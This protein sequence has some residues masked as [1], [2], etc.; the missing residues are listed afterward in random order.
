MTDDSPL[1]S[2][3]GLTK[4]YGELTAVENLSLDIAP[5][6]IF[7]MLGPNGAGKTT[8]ISC[9]SGLLQHFEG[10]VRVA[11]YDVLEHFR[12]TRQIVGVVPQE[13]NFDAFC[14]ARQTLIYQGG[15]FGRRRARQRADELLTAFGLSEKAEAN[16]RW[17]SGGM[18]RRLM[19]CKALM[20]QPA[21]LF[22]DEP[23]AGVD[24][25]LRDELWAY[26]R[27]LREEGVTIVLTTH[28][29]EEAEQLADRI[30]ILNQGRLILVDER[31]R[32]IQRL[33]S[34]W[35]RVR[36]DRPVPESL[37][38]DL[39]AYSPRLLAPDLIEFHYGRDREP[40]EGEAPP[41]DC[42][43]S[44]LRR[45]QLQVATLDGGRSS[46]ESIFRSI[47]KDDQNRNGEAHVRN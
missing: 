15:M 25:E 12:T 42:I 14:H 13:L 17:L 24:V 35:L 2:I 33:G 46:L 22:L 41:V 27:R 19:I 8:M 36:C 9:V 34:R 28:Y 6:E 16:T 1:L 20:H 11:G 45:H 43:L 39:C 18:K 3:R 38:S 21:L 31:E 7:A 29:L 5:G 30:G 10:E 37:I 44:A 23:T 26:V 4:K 32:L 47:L 40:A